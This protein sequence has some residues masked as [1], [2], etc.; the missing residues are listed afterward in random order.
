MID[1]KNGGMHISEEK[2][3]CGENCFIAMKWR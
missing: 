2:Q 3:C 1:Y